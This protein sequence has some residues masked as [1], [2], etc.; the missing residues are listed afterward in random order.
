MRSWLGQQPARAAAF[1]GVLVGLAI[2]LGFG[3]L[4]FPNQ[5]GALTPGAPSVPP[6][7]SSPPASTPQ[8]TAVLWVAPGGR[9]G[10]A[11]TRDDPLSSPQ[12]A[13][14]R[15]AITV[16]LAAGSYAAFELHRSG[17]T[18]IGPDGEP[19]RIDGQVEL[20][21]VNDVRIRGLEFTGVVDRYEPALLVEGSRNVALEQVA[22][23]GNTFGIQLRDVEAVSITDSVFTHNGSGIEIHGG[24]RDVT[25]RENRFEQN[26]RAVDDSRGANGINLYKGKGPIRIERNSFRSNFNP[27]PR[28]GTDA[29]GG[30]IE[31]YASSDVTIIENEIYDSSVMETGTQ[32]GIPCERIAFIGNVV[33]R[34]PTG[35]S[36]QGLVLRCASDSIVAHNTIHGLDDYAFDLIHNAGSFGGSIEGL[37]VVNNIVTGGRAYSI[38]NQMPSSVVID[39]NLVWNPGSR[40]RMGQ[41]LAYVANRGNTGSAAELRSWGL[42]RRGV[43][44]DPGYRDLDAGDLRVAADSPAVD[45]GMVL[46]G[47]NDSVAD[48]KPDIGYY[49]VGG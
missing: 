30:A 13:L 42:D 1:L 21:G 49:E 17:V 6:G 4:Y 23:T 28:P 27:N 9:D 44:A 26:D 39:H 15:G 33:R 10:A 2:G 34:G 8:D 24:A 40:A 37:R 25:I 46:E 20:R 12:A 16:N 29:G 48:G 19:A 22:A 43:S 45:A 36:Q 7:T 32:D 11:G 14:D 3:A 31:V 35:P 5:P 41:F 38:D 18:I 47:V